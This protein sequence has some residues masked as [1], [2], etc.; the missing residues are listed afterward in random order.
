MSGSCASTASSDASG[1][2]KIF[3]IDALLERLGRDAADG[4]NESLILV[5][6]LAIHIENAL[7]GGRD[8]FLRHRG[9]NDVPEAAGFARRAADGDLVPLLAVLIHAQDADV[10][11]VM[12]T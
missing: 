10:A 1:S 8:L 3:A 5:A 12:V 6:Q 7:H 9:T 4:V 2:R 11:D